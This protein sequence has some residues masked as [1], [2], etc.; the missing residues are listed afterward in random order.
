VVSY[1]CV[2][3]PLLLGVLYSY[4]ESEEDGIGLCVC[5][6]PDEEDW[7]VLDSVCGCVVMHGQAWDVMDGSLNDSEYPGRDIHFGLQRH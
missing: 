4:F 1:S 7:L 3:E 5:A 6:C 2:I